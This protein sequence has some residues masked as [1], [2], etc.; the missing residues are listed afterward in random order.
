MARGKKSKKVKLDDEA[1]TL[2]TARPCT[3]SRTLF[4]ISKRTE[5][6]YTNCGKS[7]SKKEQFFRFA[8]WMRRIDCHNKSKI[9]IEY[10]IFI[11][12]RLI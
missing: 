2:G 11:E 4:E 9:G 6:N 1:T 5:L 3:L 10:F 7:Q 12:S 8:E